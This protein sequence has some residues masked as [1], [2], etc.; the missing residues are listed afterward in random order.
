MYQPFINDK[1][2]N[3][4]GYSVCVQTLEE[5]QFS[6]GQRHQ[7]HIMALPKESSHL[8][9]DLIHVVAYLGQPQLDN[10][11]NRNSSNNGRTTTRHYPMPPDKWWAAPCNAIQGNGDTWQCMKMPKTHLHT[12]K[13]W[14]TPY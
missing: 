11:S 6:C 9:M 8:R 13:N 2:H 4:E 1:K 3:I 7:S 14:Y 10:L 12:Y 5:L